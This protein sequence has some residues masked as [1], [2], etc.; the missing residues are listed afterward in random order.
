MIYMLLINDNVALVDVFFLQEVNRDFYSLSVAIVSWLMCLCH[1]AQAIE[2][3]VDSDGN[4]Y[5][6]NKIL[7]RRTRVKCFKKKK[8]QVLHF[9]TR[10]QVT[11][12]LD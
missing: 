11:W 4:F 5:C 3:V 1:P 10:K 7:E 6:I 12:K 2:N 9:D 8:N